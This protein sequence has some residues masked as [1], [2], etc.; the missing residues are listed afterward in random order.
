MGVL[1]A[2]V[3]G[4]AEHLPK[5]LAPRPDAALVGRLAADVVLVAV[6]HAAQPGSLVAPTP[7]AG[8]AA[9]EEGVAQVR[10][11]GADGGQDGAQVRHGQ[12]GHVVGGRVCQLGGVLGVDREGGQHRHLG[13]RRDAAWF[14]GG[15]GGRDAVAEQAVQQ[16]EG[17]NVFTRF[18]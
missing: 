8:L 16:V 18:V 11:D 12:G 7:A 4:P 9:E 14:G 10:V 3:E 2:A 5:V 1:R 17:G 6:V 13:R 15:M